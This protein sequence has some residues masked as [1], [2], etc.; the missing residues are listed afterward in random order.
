MFSY[1]G[2]LCSQ[3]DPIPVV[4]MLL[5]NHTTNSIA[6]WLN[7]WQRASAAAPKEAVCDFSLALL[8]ALVKAFT[9]YRDLKSYII[10]TPKN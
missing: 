8:G 10:S 7:K 1:Q 9:P 3:G 4:Q 5:E 2:V 6:N